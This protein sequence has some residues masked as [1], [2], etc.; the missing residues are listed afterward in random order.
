MPFYQV[1]ERPALWSTD[2]SSAASEWKAATDRL[3]P[4]LVSAG[5]LA[6]AQIGISAV[7]TSGP[8]VADASLRLAVSHPQL[9]GTLLSVGEALS[10]SPT[11]VGA[12]LSA[13]ALAGAAGSELDLAGTRGFQASSREL[14]AMQTA[15]ETFASTG[16]ESLGG[17]AGHAAL[18]AAERG[19]DYPNIVGSLFKRNLP[20]PYQLEYKFTFDPAGIPADVI[21]KASAQ[22]LDYSLRFQA[23]YGRVP[24]RMIK[25]FNPMTLQWQL[26]H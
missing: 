14:S 4:Y 20:G 5:G 13:T 1:L 15:F 17:R 22:T 16:Y 3:A 12:A 26:A 23:T 21:R 11:G 25:V 10:E 8:L 9:S 6:A 7:L 19:V 18:G 24:I 2:A